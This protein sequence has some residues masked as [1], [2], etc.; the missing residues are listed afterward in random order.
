M[1]TR[2][3]VPQERSTRNALCHKGVGWWISRTTSFAVGELRPRYPPSPGCRIWHIAVAVWCGVLG[4]LPPY[5]AS[6]D[7]LRRRGKPDLAKRCEQYFGPCAASLRR[8]KGIRCIRRGMARCRRTS[9]AGLAAVVRV[10]LQ[11]CRSGA[12]PSCGRKTHGG[13]LCFAFLRRQRRR[14]LA[15]VGTLALLLY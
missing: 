1:A 4:S 8:R 9:G 15:A 13:P 11:F 3:V 7:V 6:V 14:A 12:V 2:L 5:R 10:P